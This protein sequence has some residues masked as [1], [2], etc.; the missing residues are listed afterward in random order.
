MSLLFLSQGDCVVSGLIEQLVVEQQGM[1]PV[2][3]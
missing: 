1:G 3:K 2:G